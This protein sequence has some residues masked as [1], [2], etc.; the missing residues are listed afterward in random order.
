MLNLLKITDISEKNVQLFSY[1][2]I[3]SLMFL[4]ITKR[5]D[6][7]FI[8]SQFVEKPSRNDWIKRIFKYLKGTI[9]YSLIYIVKYQKIQFFLIVYCDFDWASNIDT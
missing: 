6:L 3:S 9:N 2:A 8:I 4:E 7:M 5:S 1:R